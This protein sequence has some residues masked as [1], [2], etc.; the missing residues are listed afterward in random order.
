MTSNTRITRLGLTTVHYP[1][2]DEPLHLTKVFIVSGGSPISPKGLRERREYRKK[3]DKLMADLNSD[4]VK[5]YF[6]RTAGCSCGC[7]PGFIAKETVLVDGKET[8]WIRVDTEEY[9][10]S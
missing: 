7:S 2:K 3:L 4:S 5:F 10:N 1:S 8:L 6:S 9:E